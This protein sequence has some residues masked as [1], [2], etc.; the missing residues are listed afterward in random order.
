[1]L[2]GSLIRLLTEAENRTTRVLPN[3]DNS[4]A[5]DNGYLAAC[6][7][8]PHIVL[9]AIAF[10]FLSVS[11]IDGRRITSFETPHTP[12]LATVAYVLRG[13]CIAVVTLVLARKPGEQSARS[14]K[15]FPAGLASWQISVLQCVVSLP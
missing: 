13:Y 9:A 8:S 12:R 2:S 11:P 1:M 10:A 14:R 5:T 6:G 4:C 3:P 15:P 7:V